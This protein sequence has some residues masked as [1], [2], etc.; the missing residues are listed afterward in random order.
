MKD[1]DKLRV[2]KFKVSIGCKSRP[3]KTR[4]EERGAADETTSS[5]GSCSPA[6]RPTAGPLASQQK[7]EEG[8]A[9]RVIQESSTRGRGDRAGGGGGIVCH[10]NFSL[11]LQLVGFSLD[12]ARGHVANF[13]FF[14]SRKVSYVVITSSPSPILLPP[15]FP[16]PGA[17]IL[18]DSDRDRMGR[19]GSEREQRGPRRWERGAA[20]LHGACRAAVGWQTCISSVQFIFHYQHQ[21]QG[22]LKCS[23]LGHLQVSPLVGRGYW[24]WQGW[25]ENDAVAYTPG[26]SPSTIVGLED[27]T[28]WAEQE[29]FNENDYYSLVEYRLV[30]LGSF[31][32][33]LGQP[34]L[35]VVPS[36][37]E[38]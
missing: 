14:L 20:F 15:R 29:A 24:A 37:H 2:K 9:T 38:T 27:S 5:C 4:R 34:K 22:T 19:E 13:L 8:T 28:V 35:L 36:G 16:T 11:P 17:L 23:V 18:C 7:R 1:C 3:I 32:F 6:C 31:I 25:E 10:G 26:Q 21:A 33:F 30:P 12:G